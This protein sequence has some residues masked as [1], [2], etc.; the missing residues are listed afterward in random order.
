[1]EEDLR[2]EELL[3]ADVDLEWLLGDGVDAAV[4]LD[5][6]VGVGVELVELFGDVGA[7]VAVAL[8]DGLG[9]LQRLLRRDPDLPLAQQA[10]Q[11][12]ILLGTFE[13]HLEKEHFTVDDAIISMWCLDVFSDL[14]NTMAC[15]KLER[16]GANDRLYLRHI[17]RYDT[18]HIWVKDTIHISHNFP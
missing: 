6:L 11:N 13:D 18:I 1:M 4:L 12:L 7:D 5:V 16:S 3:V 10:L 14:G 2:A 15:Y 17:F 9:R 8:L